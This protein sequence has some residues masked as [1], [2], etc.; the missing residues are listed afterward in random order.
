MLT[1]IQVSPVYQDDEFVGFMA[2]RGSIN[3]V[4]STYQSAHHKLAL[5]VNDEHN[6]N[7]RSLWADLMMMA[8]KAPNGHGVK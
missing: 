5:L 7:T 8:C 1:N 2:F 4:G 6:A 3:A